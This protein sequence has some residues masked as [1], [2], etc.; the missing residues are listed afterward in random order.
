MEFA[1]AVRDGEKLFP[2][3]FNV[4][5]EQLC[6]R[7]LRFLHGLYLHVNVCTAINQHPSFLFIAWQS[8]PTAVS[9]GAQAFLNHQGFVHPDL[10]GRSGKL[11]GFGEANH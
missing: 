4:I 8:Y 2:P 9:E 1:D 7:V 6:F 3:G 11:S 10:S 5:G